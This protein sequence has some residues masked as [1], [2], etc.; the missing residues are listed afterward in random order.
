MA[1]L[2]EKVNRQLMGSPISFPHLCAINFTA[3]WNAFGINTSARLA[4][5][6]VQDHIN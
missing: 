6:A 2:V 1:E 5:G 4:D 3:I